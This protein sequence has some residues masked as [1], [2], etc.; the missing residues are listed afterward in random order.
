MNIGE[1]I[2][3]LRASK[4]MT[5]KELAGDVITRNMLSQIENGS[6]NPSLSTLNYLAERLGVPVG[7]LV[8][9]GEAGEAFY[10]KSSNYNNI[11]H[12]YKS[13]EWAICRDLCISCLS[14]GEDN[15]LM[16]MLC[17]A[18]AE[19]GILNFEDGQLKMAQALFDEALEYAPRT[20]FDT[21]GTVYKISC[22][23]NI[24]YEISP[25]LSVDVPELPEREAFVFKSDFCRYSEAFFAN[26]LPKDESEWENK[27]YFYAL[28]AK[29]LIS[30]EK[31]DP[32][33]SLLTY[34]CGDEKLPK[35]VIYLA[36]SDY[37]ICCKETEEYKDAYETA[38]IKLH[39]F[40]KMLADI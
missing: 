9:G 29:N 26:D 8:S 37:E 30:S 24:M 5:Q 28:N 21:S 31:Y 39:L 18:S 32:A 20:V 33:C 12:A 25:T 22:Y 3:E 16:Y 35:P 17:T 40:E 13:G 4:M 15:E 1:K 23:V 19:L 27:S 14:D 38:Q 34:V 36:L 7:Y 10:K 11:I 2:K 6:A